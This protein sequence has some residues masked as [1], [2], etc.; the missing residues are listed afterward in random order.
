MRSIRRKRSGARVFGLRLLPALL[1]AGYVSY[2]A[3]RASA[4]DAS[5]PARQWRKLSRSAV[6]L[7]A[8]KDYS[9]A[10]AVYFADPQSGRVFGPL[11]LQLPAKPFSGVPAPRVGAAPRVKT[12]ALGEVVFY[13][14]VTVA[15]GD[16]PVAAADEGTDASTAPEPPLAGTFLVFAS[17]RR[18]VD[19]ADLLPKIREPAAL[20]LLCGYPALREQCEP[21][22]QALRD[23]HEQE[24]AA[25]GLLLGGMKSSVLEY[26]RECVKAAPL[27]SE[28][29]LRLLAGGLPNLALSAP[30]E[31]SDVE[32]PPLQA[33][34]PAARAWLRGDVAGAQTAAQA[35]L[36]AAH[37]EGFGEQRAADAAASGEPQPGP[38]GAGDYSQFRDAARILKERAPGFFAM[39]AAAL[40]SVVAEREAYALGVRTDRTAHPALAFISAGRGSAVEAV[41]TGEAGL[42]EPVFGRPLRLVLRRGPEG[43]ERKRTWQIVACRAGSADSAGVKKTLQLLAGVPETIDGEDGGRGLA[44][45]YLA[46]AAAHGWGGYSWTAWHA[47]T[48]Q[49]GDPWTLWAKEVLRLNPDAEAARQMQ[50]YLRRVAGQKDFGALGSAGLSVAE[51]YLRRRK[52]DAARKWLGE[53]P[54]VIGRAAETYDA[55]G[56]IGPANRLAIKSLQTVL[57]CLSGRPA[58][59]PDGL[60]RRHAAAYLT[61]FVRDW[62]EAS[63]REWLQAFQRLELPL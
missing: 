62:D 25:I 59:W 54:R 44:C 13:T 49:D 24:A 1:L 26:L 5:A 46:Q 23:P 4:E 47:Q 20:G 45:A 55:R 10:G 16:C 6:Y 8:V 43:P 3:G 27:P 40:R 35:A 39:T 7:G 60:D 63:R 21:R 17:A 29:C 34:I 30:G 31:E 48:R 28:T 57:D 38:F 56:D 19:W 51:F 11:D 58:R 37:L 9:G 32:Q 52:W 53:L 15:A 41:W 50:V 12:G 36:L 18:Q 2:P 61:E 33:L 22:I 14:A 42:P